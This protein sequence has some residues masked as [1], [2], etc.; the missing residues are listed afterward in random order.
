MSNKRYDLIRNYPPS[1]EKTPLIIPPELNFVYTPILSTEEDNPLRARLKYVTSAKYEGDWQSIVHTHAFCELFLVTGGRGQFF[2]NGIQFPVFKNDLIVI[3]PLTEHTEFSLEA[4]PL[5]YIVLGIEG[6]QFSHGD[7][8][9]NAP[10]FIHIAH[11]AG[12][13]S[14]KVRKY[15]EL[16]LDE[17]HSKNNDHDTICQC[18]LNIILILILRYKKLDLS[19][20]VSK[21]ISAECAAAKNYID[22][23]FKEAI[24]L[25]A[26]AGVLHQNKYYLAHSFKDAFG[27]SPIRYLVERRIE[28]SKRLL[29]D[30]DYSI[31]EIASIAGFASASNFSQVFRR[32]VSLSP[33][34]YR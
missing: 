14:A 8:S 28:E 22:D 16:L 10:P 26:L 2:A 25:E 27:I 30:T 17:I 32:V 20:T 6:L 9:Y 21:H 19:I 12:T 24:T 23:H 31:G 4:N 13:I 29:T 7:Q 18:L 1:T 34:E 11:N 15:I 3:N 33:N 5:E